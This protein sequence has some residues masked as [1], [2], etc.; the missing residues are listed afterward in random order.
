MTVYR[1]I[2]TQ[3]HV[4]FGPVPYVTFSPV[5][6]QSNIKHTEASVLKFRISAHKVN[7]QIYPEGPSADYWTLDISEM[8]DK[9][10][11]NRSESGRRK[12]QSEQ[13]EGLYRP[14]N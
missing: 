1:L 12:T 14:L 3:S 10:E 4:F 7:V 8:A 13:I 5:E 6:S 9:D 11:E 2:S